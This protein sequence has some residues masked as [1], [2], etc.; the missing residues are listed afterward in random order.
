MLLLPKTQRICHQSG[1]RSPTPVSRELGDRGGAFCGIQVVS[2]KLTLRLQ[3]RLDRSE[4]A[5]LRNPV[6]LAGLYAGG[7]FVVS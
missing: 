3:A 6:D 7:R 1:S 4:K 5:S 2:E